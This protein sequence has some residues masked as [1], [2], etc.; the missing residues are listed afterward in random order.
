METSSL[1]G[2]VILHKS[3]NF[4]VPYILLPKNGK[5]VFYWDIGLISSNIQVGQ[6]NLVVLI[7]RFT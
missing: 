7:A 2:C 3:L 5:D 6:E 1:A 4:Y